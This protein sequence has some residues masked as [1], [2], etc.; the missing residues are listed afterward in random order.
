MPRARAEPPARRGC[1]PAPGARDGQPVV[2]DV[3]R[4]PSPSTRHRPIIRVNCAI[5]ALWHRGIVAL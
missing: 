3:P 5:V 1:A 4:C 2:A